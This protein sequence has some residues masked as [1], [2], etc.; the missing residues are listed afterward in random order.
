MAQQVY[1]IYEKTL[2]FP[3]FIQ[4]YGNVDPTQPPDGSTLQERLDAL[5][6]KYPDTGVYLFPL[7]TAV[8]PEMQK[9]D[10]ITLTLVDLFDQ[11]GVLID[12]ADIAP[13]A[14]A[15]L[16]AAQKEADI[17]ANLPSWSQVETVINNISSMADAKAFL[18]KLSRAVYWNTKNRP[19]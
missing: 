16:D 10:T 19:D 1:V 2:P 9:F 11:F 4:F 5:L 13:K 8:D 6:I 3:G 12:P 18:L 7:G 17:S 14:Q 15:V